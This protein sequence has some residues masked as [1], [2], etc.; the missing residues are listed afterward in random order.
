MYLPDLLNENKL[1]R[2]TYELKKSGHAEKE[3]SALLYRATSFV[4]LLNRINI[5]NN[6][7]V[8][9]FELFEDQT[10]VESEI[11]IVFNSRSLIELLNEISPALSTLRIMQDLLLPTLGKVYK[12]SVPSSIIDGVK[13]LNRLPFSEKIKNLIHL[14]WINGGSKLRNYRVVDQHHTTLVEHTFLQLTPPRRVLVIFPDNPE[15]KTH[16]K[17]TYE[18]YIEGIAY[19]GQM[20]MKTHELYE[21]IA[22]SLGCNGILVEKEIVMEQLGYL[23]PYR[24]RTLSLWYEE[25]IRKS[26]NGK[27][28]RNIS[29][30]KLNHTE[31]G[32][33]EVQRLL[34]GDDKIKLLN[35]GLA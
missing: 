26:E 20:F 17:F 19:I 4:V 32:N 13:K 8:K 5:Q 28:Q 30:I 35:E 2:K 25:D 33:I 18:K 29:A 34:L 1:F 16:K 12:T 14:Y 6:K 23:C 22:E 10:Q 31:K 9:E 11:K 15:V 24:R 7:C 21:R 3:I 27:L